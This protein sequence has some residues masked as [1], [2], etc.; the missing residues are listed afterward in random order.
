MLTRLVSYTLMGS[1][2]A[3]R[4]RLPPGT[5][6]RPQLPLSPPP[7]PK[8]PHPPTPSRSSHPNKPCGPKSWWTTRPP[9]IPPTS[10]APPP[11]RNKPSLAMQAAAVCQNR[12]ITT[13][14]PRLVSVHCFDADYSNR[15]RPATGDNTVCPCRDI[16]WPP[17]SPPDPNP[18]TH[19]PHSF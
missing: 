6:R 4:A 5:S 11:D 2:A 15:F 3:G 19:A 12:L 9:P 14:I 10:L 13:T 8:P 16:P 7:P 18:S 1:S 17:P